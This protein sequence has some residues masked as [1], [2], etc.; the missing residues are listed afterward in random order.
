LHH[1]MDGDRSLKAR[2]LRFAKRPWAEKELLLRRRFK[3]AWNRVLAGTPIPV[4]LPY[5]A[6]WLATNDAASDAIFAGHFEPAEMHVVERY[7]RPGMTVLDIGA[8]HG[9]YTLLAAKQVGSTGRVI[10]FEPSPRELERL[11][12]HLRLNHATHAEVVELALG[13]E[14]GQTQFF[15]VEG[16]ESGCNSLRPPDVADPR[17]QIVVQRRTLDQVC[18]ERS[19]GVVDFVKLDVEGGELDVLRGGETFFQRAPRP[20]VLCE[21]AD[22][23]TKPWGYPAHR[24]SRSFERLGFRWYSPRTN[25][26]LEPA[27]IDLTKPLNE[28]L[29][30]SPPERD[31]D[32]KTLL[33]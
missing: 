11:R 12:M 1:G 6:W 32:I 9:F 30:A 17:R 27:N 29:V 26:S 23:R 24:S 4:R 8:H 5:G 2:V 21:I 33:V 18:L 28:N 14:E 16:V 10:A 20:I 7:L 25:G 22:R 31:A 19:I 13:A 15:V 3:R